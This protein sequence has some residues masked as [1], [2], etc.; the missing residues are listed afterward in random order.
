MILISFVLL[1]GFFWIQSRPEEEILTKFVDGPLLHPPNPE[2]Y[3]EAPFVQESTRTYSLATRAG[4]VER[5]I[6]ILIEF[7]DVSHDSSNSIGHFDDLVFSGSGSMYDYYREASYGQ[8][9]IMGDVAP[10]WFQS[11]YPMSEYGADSSS[12]VDDLNGPI[13]RL[14]TEAVKLADADVDFS[15]YDEDGN[16]VV[17]HIIVVHAGSGQETLPTPNS[18][19]S[20]HW[21]VI[22]A[23]TSSP[24]DQ[25]LVVDGVEVYGYTMLSENSPMGVFAHEFGHDLG[26][27][28][29]YDT[30]DSSEG[31]GNW[32]IMAGGSWLGWP[33]GTQPSLPGAFSKVKLGWVDPIVVEAPMIDVSITS[34]WDT[35]VIY[36]LPIGDSDGEYFLVENRQQHGYD[37]LLPG[38]GLL[39]WHVDEDVPD[40][41]NDNHRMVDIEEADE[42]DGDHPLD[43]TD[44]WAD[45]KDGFHPGSVPN[46][47]AYGNVRTGWRVKN[48]GP[49]GD[50]MTADISKQ[51]LDDVVV[52]SVDTDSFVQASTFVNIAVNISNRGA[53]NQ[54][55]LPVNL[56]VY[57]Q[58]YGEQN[59]IYWDV[60]EISSLELEEYTKL[61]YNYQPTSTGTY[62]LEV[63]AIL[64]DDEIPEDNDRFAHFNSNLMYFW[65]DVESGNQSWST[66]TS[67]YRYRWDILED[68]PQGSYSPTHSWHFGLFE[69]TPSTVNRT[70]FTMTSDN[71]LVSDGSSAY[72]VMHHKY[73]FE[74][75]VELGGKKPEDLK[76]DTGIL[77]ITTDGTNWT[78]IES[79]GRSPGDGVQFDW[80]MESFDISGYLQPGANTIRLRYL[81]ESEGVPIGRGWWLDDVGV[82][83]EEPQYGLVFKV[84]DH[85][86]T[87]EP[88]SIASFLFKIV[89][90]GDFEDEFRLTAE[91]V[92]SS[93]RYVITEDESNVGVER[94]DL[95]LGVDDYALVYLKVE[96]STSAERGGKYNATAVARSLTES[97]IEKKVNVT[98]AIATGL[99]DL[100]L[101]DVCF[102]LLLLMVLVLP[103]A[104][105]VDYLRKTRKHF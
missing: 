80:K 71:I 98:V 44:V 63:R 95:E 15:D 38:S 74:R 78:D 61:I 24:G 82:V 23:D 89:N 58:E 60:Q 96:T 55:D 21:A 28:D 13:Y 2:T 81:V 50:L 16:G 25:D 87:V 91:D 99:F 53:R 5:V 10:T 40:N 26:L 27:P 92:P 65:D 51:V 57:Y 88:G 85:D 100:T 1:S 17:D 4:P 68:Y 105:V 45:N 18:I 22:D 39:I 9:S 86:K 101:G 47:N 6:V 46:S 97:D 70:E 48:I 75:I 30:D 69:G 64:D 49:A 31:V 76:S 11:S 83:V 3:D 102:I 93:W 19:W 14:V 54:T 73:I 66:N 12:G 34:V 8:T 29:L 84:Y 72:V 42:E 56:S 43:A 36:K 35:P 7:T 41:S 62:I 67:L 33:Q 32:D 104:I 52:V 90:V 20:H 77:Q 37:S 79:W 94:L 103:I 59:L